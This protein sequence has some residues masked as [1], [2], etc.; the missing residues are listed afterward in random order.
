VPLGSFAPLAR[1]AATRLISLQKNS[2]VEQ[3]AAEG[4]A[5]PVESPGDSFDAGPDAFIDAA[6]VI[7]GL[8]LV[9]T[10]DTSIA[11]LA[12]ALGKPVWVALK[13]VPDWRW[14]LEREDTPWYPQMR[15]FRQARRGEWDAVFARMAQELEALQR[16]A[17]ATA[18]VLIPGAVGELIDKITILEIKSERIADPAKLRNVTH[19]LTLLRRLRG[20]S[21]F[22]GC[23]LDALG[24]KLKAANLALW[25]IEDEIRLC[26]QC[27]DFGERFIALARSVYK[28][29][30]ERA[31]LKRGINL[32]CGSA[33]VE[34]KSY[35]GGAA[36]A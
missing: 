26:E 30:D 4:I 22:H 35:A 24:A 7:A 15:L 19:E 28:T 8:D 29:N 33:I 10:C 21:G 3:L 16:Q 36:P 1:I 9:I 20:E 34:E 32:L 18:S 13:S 11:H 27:G 6:A 17:P 5:F 25:E 12:G 31:A 14:M 2:G 23:E